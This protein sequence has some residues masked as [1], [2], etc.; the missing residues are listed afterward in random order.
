MTFLAL[1]RR[2]ATRRVV[3]NACIGNAVRAAH[4]CHTQHTFLTLDGTHTHQ[5]SSKFVRQ[6]LSVLYSTFYDRNGEINT[7]RKINSFEREGQRLANTTCT[8]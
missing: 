2:P 5:D 4:V 1:R 8:V 7:D 6:F 3:R